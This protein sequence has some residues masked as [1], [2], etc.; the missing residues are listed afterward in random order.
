MNAKVFP[1]REEQMKKKK[2]GKRKD[3]Q[4][5]FALLRQTDVEHSPVKG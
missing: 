3:S 1:E 2:I 4:T 5:V